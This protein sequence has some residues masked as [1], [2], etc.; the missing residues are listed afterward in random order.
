MFSSLQFQHQTV[1]EN[2]FNLKWWL[3][4]LSTFC[5][6]LKLV[7]EHG[8]VQQKYAKQIM[9]CIHG[10]GYELF[11]NKYNYHPRNHTRKCA[12]PQ[13]TCL[14]HI[15]KLNVTF[16]LFELTVSAII[17]TS[18]LIRTIESL[19]SYDQNHFNCFN[20]P[21]WYFCHW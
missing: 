1:K 13:Y 6:Q 16:W 20:F 18:I 7:I 15:L 4:W 5:L 11:L 14:V 19:P 21:T 12:I 2:L 10:I 3:Q 9:L 17:D 8:R